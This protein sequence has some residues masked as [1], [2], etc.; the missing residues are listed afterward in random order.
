[1]TRI[2]RRVFVSYTSELALYPNQ[3]HSWVTAATDAIARAGHSYLDMALMAASDVPPA[4]S[5]T[6][7][8][9]DTE[10]YVAIVGF[11]YGSVA[12]EDPSRSFVELEF[13]AAGEAGIPR[14][15]FL[16]DDEVALPMPRSF[17]VDPPEYGERQE[18]FRARLRNSGITLASVRSPNELQTVLLQ[19][20]VTLTSAQKHPERPSVVLLSTRSSVEFSMMLTRQLSET[21]LVRTWPL[22]EEIETDPRR[23]RLLLSWLQDADLGVLVLMPPD[24]ATIAQDSRWELM[25]SRSAWYEIGL[26]SGTM[27]P[28][29][30]EVVSPAALRLPGIL[31]SPT[32]TLPSSGPTLSLARSAAE[33]VTARLRAGSPDRP[34]GSSPP[35]YTCFLSYAQADS[36]FVDQLYVDLQDSGIACWLDRERLAIGQ[37]WQEEVHRQLGSSDKLLL[38][39]SGAS[40]RSPWV[41]LEL[42]RAM[43]LEDQQARE[44]VMPIGIDH[45]ALGSSSRWVAELVRERQIA[46]FHNW[47]DENSYR[48]S[49]RHLVRD[50]T[51]SSASDTLRVP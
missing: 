9:A 24:A 15:V 20:L 8:V 6:R 32:I 10:I 47:Q 42:Q 41:H 51:V 2:P 23:S 50:L 5:V 16:V 3:G 44:I 37:R 36:D 4:E 27:G 21:A 7:S 11:R 46:D 28:E 40:A 29:H 31:R 45:E 33:A 18:Q 49:L 38:V 13:E 12:R 17:F 26:A 34:S 48:R 14:L 22:P 39:L 25:L 19:A 35:R 1:M 43:T 30:I